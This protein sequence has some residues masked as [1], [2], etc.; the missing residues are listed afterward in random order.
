MWKLGR[1][2]ELSSE[3]IVASIGELYPEICC[4]NLPSD[5]MA[6]QKY[7]SPN[8]GTEV[9]KDK[10]PRPKLGWSPAPRGT[11]QKSQLSH[12]TQN[13]TIASQPFMCKDPKATLVEEGHLAPQSI[14]TVQSVTNQE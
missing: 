3:H 4:N 1:T 12:V 8:K 11:G 5:F 2:I 7:R 6:C 9:Q 13:G 14:Q 10:N